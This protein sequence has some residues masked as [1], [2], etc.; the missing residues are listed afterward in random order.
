VPAL[1]L[2]TVVR[3]D[4]STSERFTVLD[5]FAADRM[6]LLYAISRTL[7][8]LGLSVWVAKIGT[9]L[10]QVVDVFYVTDQEGRKIENEERLQHIRTRLLHAIENLQREEQTVGV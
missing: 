3:A 7:F 6:G 1:S 2:P 9:Y 10:D 5:I 4:N 8:E